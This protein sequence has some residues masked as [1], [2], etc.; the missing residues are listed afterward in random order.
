MLISGKDDLV[1]CALGVGSTFAYLLQLNTNTAQGKPISNSSVFEEE[2]E[3]ITM[4]SA[5]GK[6][7]LT[8]FA[9]Y[10]STLCLGALM[11]VKLLVV[12]VKR[13]VILLTSDHIRVI[14][15]LLQMTKVRDPVE[16]VLVEGENCRVTIS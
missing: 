16:V 2:E 4:H 7:L 14:I 8:C 9:H 15:G 5:E 6:A 3:K 13:K 1:V 11:G 10:L 12:L